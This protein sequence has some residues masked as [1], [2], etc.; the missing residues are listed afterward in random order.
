[1][2]VGLF[3]VD[4]VRPSPANRSEAGPG[5]AAAQTERTPSPTIAAYSSVRGPGVHR[6]ADTS[7]VF[8]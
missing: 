3:I 4:Q 1:M 2:S 8:D 7:E 5:N 6:R